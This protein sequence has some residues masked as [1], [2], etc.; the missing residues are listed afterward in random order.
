MQALVDDRSCSEVTTMKDPEARTTFAG[1]DERTDTE[2]PE[3]Y[4]QRHGG[5]NPVTFAEAIR[6][7]PQAVETTV[8]Y[9]APSDIYLS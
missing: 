9:P 8:A 7:L 6:D 5:D 4:R 2:L 1:V 3:W